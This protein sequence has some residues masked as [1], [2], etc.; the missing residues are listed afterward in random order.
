MTRPVVLLLATTLNL[1]AADWPQWR[2]PSQNGHADPGQSPPTEFSD[3]KNVLWS[4]DVPGRGHGSPTVVAD[5]VFLAVADEDAK[6]QGVLCLDRTTGKQRW[7]TTV[8]DGPFPKTNKKAS[9]AS[10]TPACDGERV[11]ITFVNDGAA[12]LTALTVDGKQLWQKKIS[13]YVVHQGYGSSPTIYKN[14]VLVCA[15]NKS[16]GAT[17]AYDRISGKQ[18]WK[19]DRAKLPNYPS[20]VVFNLNGRDQLLLQGTELVTSLDPLTGKV[21]WEHEGATTECVSSLATD[22]THVFTSGG[23]PKN[24]V[25]AVVAD[26]S[27]KVTWENA[28]RVYVPSMLVDNGHLFAVQDN[29]VAICWNAATGEEMWKERLG[30]T[31][32]SSPVLVGKHIYSCDEGGQFFVHNADPK[33]FK[34]VAKNQLGDETLSTPTICNSQIFARVI[35][36]SNRHRQEKLYCI[37]K[38]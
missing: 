24:H 33:N 6:T 15:D 18:V 16:G 10:T 22:G 7:L 37:G 25:A 21:I 11:Y 20:P 27:A 9:H 4:A 8:H 23:Y 2:G 38:K 31:T 32:S 34:I 19:H 30:R 35:H 1:Q 13:G 17:A 28:S 29:G 5:R 26:G 12:H 3:T 36:K 14:L